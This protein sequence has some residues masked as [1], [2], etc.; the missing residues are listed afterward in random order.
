MATRANPNVAR[1]ST[2]TTRDRGMK[3]S[4]S[5]SANGKT[6]A[7]RARLGSIS[8]GRMANPTGLQYRKAPITSR[9]T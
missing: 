7:S 2:I 6:L 1:G 8:K 4:M 9:M 3:D 5:A